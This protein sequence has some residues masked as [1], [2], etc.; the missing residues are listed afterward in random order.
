[1][2]HLSDT[3]RKMSYFPGNEGVPLWNVIFS[4]ILFKWKDSMAAFKRRGLEN[5]LAPSSR[6][7]PFLE[8]PSTI[9]AT[10][11]VAET[12]GAA[13]TGRW[14]ALA[15]FCS[16]VQLCCGFSSPHL[17]PGSAPLFSLLSPAQVLEGRSDSTLLA[18][19]LEFRPSNPRAGRI[20]GDQRSW[21]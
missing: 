21:S 1:M 12:L 11:Q 5:N 13:T 3:R 9:E 10:S 7:A 19:F 16:A 2:A 6:S 15:T 4:L 18:L 17:R 14:G 8:T 20:L